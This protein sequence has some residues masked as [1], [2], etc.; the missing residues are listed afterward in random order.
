MAQ[1][2]YHRADDGAADFPAGVE[3]NVQ[4]RAW[5]VI[6]AGVEVPRGTCPSDSVTRPAALLRSPTASRS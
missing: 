3:G 6:L 1:Y 2:S 5:H 4:A